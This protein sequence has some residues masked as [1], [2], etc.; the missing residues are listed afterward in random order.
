[1][2]YLLVGG[3]TVCFVFCTFF[4]HASTVYAVVL[5]VCVSVHYKPVLYR[6]DWTDRAGFWHGGCLPSFLH[7]ALGKF[8]YLQK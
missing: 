5:C 7:C 2:T 8:G 6:N 1:M 3:S 4:G